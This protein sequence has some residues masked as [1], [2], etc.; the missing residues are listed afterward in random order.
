MFIRKS[1]GNT[2]IIGKPSQDIVS[3]WFDEWMKSYW[4]FKTG[5]VHLRII[6]L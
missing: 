6:E 4:P 3:L 1:T 5:I 2:D